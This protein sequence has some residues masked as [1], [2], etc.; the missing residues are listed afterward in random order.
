[1]NFRALI[2]LCFVG[3][4]S[5]LHG[6]IALAQGPTKLSVEVLKNY[7]Y[8]LGGSKPVQ[9]TDGKQLLSREELNDMLDCEE[10]NPS[11]EAEC[12]RAKGFYDRK[13][14]SLHDIVKIELGPVSKNGNQA[15]FVVIDDLGNDYWGGNGIPSN[16]VVVQL[17]D[18]KLS[19]AGGFWADRLAIKSF[20]FNK[21]SV[22]F[23]YD[24]GKVFVRGK[25]EQN[26][27]TK[28]IALDPRVYKKP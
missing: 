16:V 4:V 27:A 3:A 14:N 6:A 24:E 23:V 8:Q 10:N 15:A 7:A 17:I 20:K 5:L 1:M 28:K 12:T 13:E 9:F 26:R 19:Q 25:F 21:D 18:G 22:T 2:V 11:K